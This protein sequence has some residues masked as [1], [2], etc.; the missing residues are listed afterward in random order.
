MEA[1]RLA[2]EAT[3]PEALSPTLKNLI[4]LYSIFKQRAII[5]VPLHVTPTYLFHFS[6]IIRLN[7]FSE[8]LGFVHVTSKLSILPNHAE[9]PKGLAPC[10]TLSP[11]TKG[12]TKEDFKL[13]SIHY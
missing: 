13:A 5:P 9:H 1:H 6:E 7:T 12:F 2:Q 4:M 11:F 10:Y 8:F 3:K